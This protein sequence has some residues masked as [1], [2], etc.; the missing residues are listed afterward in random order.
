MID[1]YLEALHKAFP[2]ARFG[3]NENDLGVYEVWI[4]NKSGS[5][6]YASGPT[7]TIAVERLHTRLIPAERA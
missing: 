6:G 5:L 3:S 2:D 4:K 7:L 1:R